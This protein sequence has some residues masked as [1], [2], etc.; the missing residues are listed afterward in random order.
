MKSLILIVKKIDYFKLNSNYIIHEF[1]WPRNG[2][3]FNRNY[4][5]KETLSF[6]K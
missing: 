2:Y 1:S 6:Y 5:T 3:F 4:L